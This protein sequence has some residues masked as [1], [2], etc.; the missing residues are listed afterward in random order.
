M[1]VKT[2]H[3]GVTS[4]MALS[5]IRVEICSLM[6]AT[7]GLGDEGREFCGEFRCS[8]LACLGSL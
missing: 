1:S 3:M 2:C 5:C 4:S 8:V 7:S 6:M